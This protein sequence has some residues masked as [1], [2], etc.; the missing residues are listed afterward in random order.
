MVKLITNN[1]LCL[2]I[3]GVLICSLWAS[4]QAEAK[5]IVDIQTYHDEN[6]NLRRRFAAGESALGKRDAKRIPL[7]IDKILADEGKIL[8]RGTNEH[9]ILEK[10][11]QHNFEMNNEDYIMSTISLDSKLPSIQE[12]EIFYEYA[13]NDVQLSEK[14]SD[15]NEDLIIIAPTNEAISKLSLKPWQFPRDIDSLESEGASDVDID[16][17]IEENILKFVRSHVVTYND[18]NSYK[19]IRKGVTLLRSVAMVEDCEDCKGDILLKKENDAYYVASIKDEKFHL[20]EN[21]E[22]GSNGV[23]L[24]IDSCLEWP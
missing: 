3:C 15:D 11:E 14:L 2:G 8:K 21:I 10:E 1:V 9:N 20:V 6:G 18:E 19:K 12:V 7:D 5:K 13:R 4:S 22:T 17:A 16:N 24:I 23:I